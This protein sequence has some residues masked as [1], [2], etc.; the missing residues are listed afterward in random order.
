MRKKPRK[1]AARKRKKR[2]RYT[3][4]ETTGPNSL[5]KLPPIDRRDVPSPNDPGVA[6]CPKT[7]NL[8][9]SIS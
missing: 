4:D 7:T 8:N 2:E 9:Y 3:D 1:I 5:E 6:H